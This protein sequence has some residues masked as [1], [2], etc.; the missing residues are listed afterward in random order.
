MLQSDFS[1]CV[2]SQSSSSCDG[3]VKVWNIADGSCV[4][5]YTDVH[6]KTNDVRSVFRNAIIYWPTCLKR[7]ETAN[8]ISALNLIIS[9]VLTRLRYLR[10]MTLNGHWTCGN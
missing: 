3:T 7:V 8:F 2:Q 9:A 6:P 10:H 4:H 1:I 5:T